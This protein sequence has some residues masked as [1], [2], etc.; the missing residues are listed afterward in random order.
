MRRN[1]V[2]SVI[3]ARDGEPIGVVT[4]RDLALRI[5][6][7]A[8]DA[9]V[10]RVEQVMSPEPIFLSVRRSLDDAIA[11]MRDLGVRRLPVIND[12]SQLV[13]IISMDD[14]LTHIARQIGQLSE[15]IQRELEFG[16]AVGAFL[17]PSDRANHD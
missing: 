4:D 2:G 15:A 9:A 10:V 1:N 11:T 16:R 8:R 3:V 14:V 5:V 17:A 7:E 12:K 13:G 6:A